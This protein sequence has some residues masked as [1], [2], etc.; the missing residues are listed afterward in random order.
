M[1]AKS[2][3]SASFVEEPSHFL[4]YI[5]DGAGFFDT[6]TDRLRD[7]GLSVTSVSMIDADLDGDLD[8]FFGEIGSR[9]HN[10]RRV[11]ML[12]D[13]GI[14]MQNWLETQKRLQE[15]GRNY[16]LPSQIWQ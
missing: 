2:L 12:C 6:K 5:N 14:A 10:L 1:I 3:P 7:P 11:A 8:L 15:I 16:H 4:F 9:I 13:D